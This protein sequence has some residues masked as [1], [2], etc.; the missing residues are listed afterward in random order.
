VITTVDGTLDGTSDNEITTNPV[1]DEMVKIYDFLSVDGTTE[2]GTT[3]GLEIDVGTVDGT[4]VGVTEITGMVIKCDD[5]TVTN[6]VDGTVDGTNVNEITT[7]PGDDLMVT[8][9]V[10]LIVDGKSVVWIMTGDET[11]EPTVTY[12]GT[13]VVVTT[14][15]GTLTT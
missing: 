14:V 11:V 9:W 8:Y 15:V 5:G 4:T 12:F 2:S 6:L 13:E 7:S 10:D 1:F 3:T